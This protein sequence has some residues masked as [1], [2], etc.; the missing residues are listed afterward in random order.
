[1]TQLPFLENFVP[2]FSG[3]KLAVWLCAFT[4][5][6]NGARFETK[7]QVSALVIV[8]KSNVRFVVARALGPPQQVLVIWVLR[9]LGNEL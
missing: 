9:M 3:G 6:G 1:M 8:P 2:N 4:M 7:C 5:W